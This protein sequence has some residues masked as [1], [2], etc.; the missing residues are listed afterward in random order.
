MSEERR[1]RL[2]EGDA[3]D[4][5]IRWHAAL[6]QLR[7]ARARIAELEEREG[8]WRELVEAAVSHENTS[9]LFADG[10]VPTHRVSESARRLRELR[11]RLGL[12]GE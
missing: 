11:Q 10:L 12:E 3:V 5:R 4:N 2:A 1:K 7:E 6:D 9:S 8:W